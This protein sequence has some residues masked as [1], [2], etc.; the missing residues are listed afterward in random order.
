MLGEHREPVC[1]LSAREPERC[2][3]ERRMPGLDA[4]HSGQPGARVPGLQQVADAR[5]RV[6]AALKAADQVQP[7]DVSEAVDA[8]PAASL[9]R[10]QQAH[11]VVLADC[12][13][14]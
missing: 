3:V 5:E 14:R 1:Q 11:R 2:L 6:A 7:L 8:D 13:D 9:R 12:P 4:E 10:R